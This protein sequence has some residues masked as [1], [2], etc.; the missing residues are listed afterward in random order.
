MI[1]CLKSSKTLAHPTINVP[2]SKSITNRALIL[3]HLYGLPLPNN[4]SDSDDSEAVRKQLH[5]YQ[6]GE[7]QFHIEEGGT[8]LRFLVAFLAAKGEQ[9]YLITLGRAIAE[10]PHDDLIDALNT[11]GFNVTGSENTICVLPKSDRIADQWPVDSSKSSQYATAL[12]LIA[13]SVG[14]DIQIELTGNSVSLS[15]LD[16]TIKQMQQAGFEVGRTDNI[17]TC[18]PYNAAGSIPKVEA[19]WSSASYF[20]AWSVITGQALS[21]EQLVSNSLQPDHQIVQTAMALGAEVSFANGALSIVPG[22]LSVRSL[23]RDYS[24][25]PD[26]AMTEYVMCRLLH[27]ELNAS[28][29]D[30]L[31]H[32]ESNRW[33]IIQQLMDDFE[34]GVDGFDTY[35]DHRLAMCMALCS[36]VRPICIRN[37]EVVS[38]SFPD[39]WKQFEKLGV[40]ITDGK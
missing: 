10:R 16:M 12:A 18:A 8:S 35:N 29:I 4:L 28:G 7:S 6:S 24:D 37:P 11:A 23:T 31:K 14:K 33:E 22:E 20:V 36:S 26:I 27:I 38:K 39:F 30:H 15:Y 19:D 17:V 32:K 3:S 34:A 25:C 13:P 21:I 2:L 9:E 1:L 40:D 5:K